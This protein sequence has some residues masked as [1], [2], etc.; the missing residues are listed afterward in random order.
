LSDSTLPQN[1]ENRPCNR[2]VVEKINNI[3]DIHDATTNKPRS[4]ATGGVGTYGANIIKSS[5]RSFF[6]E[7]ATAVKG[8]DA[9]IWV[10]ILKIRLTDLHPIFKDLDLIA[11][12]QL[13]I[14]YRVNTG[15][16]MIQA[17][18]SGDGTSASPYSTSMSLLGTTMTS[19]TVCPIMITSGAAG[20]PM[21]VIGGNSGRDISFSFGVL[22]NA[23]T[24]KG[25]LDSFLPYNTTQLQVPFYDLVD[26]RPIINKPVKQIRYL[27][28]YAQYIQNQ[29]GLGVQDT[30]MNATF[31]IQLPSTHKNIKYVAVLPFANT[32]SGHYAS[33]NVAGLEQFQSP[34]D[35][36]PWT[37]C[38][39]ALI[40][41]FQVR[42]GNKNVFSKTQDYDYECFTHEFSKLG[43]VNGDLTTEMNSGIIDFNQ[44]SYV[45]RILV[46]DCSRYTEKDVP[47]SVQ[48][49]GTN[50]CC[51]GL[52]LLAFIV[53]ERDILINRITGEIVE[54][55]I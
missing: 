3:G 33:S 52:N 25:D 10:Y 40:K 9:G 35:S 42:L 20:Q 11:Y 39:G 30:Q 18:R 38:P 55:S 32:R 26:A 45:Q 12:P 21:A 37:L 46:A 17:T 51:Q 7:K 19:G 13:K 15:T 53:Y 8:A 48:I 49:S 24:S 23:F 43:A 14:Q 28:C 5:G 44:W 41:N 47:V 16:T 2:S 36:A 6:I 31:N 22:Q 34:F 50:V 29:V 1:Q 27:D 54:F 4:W